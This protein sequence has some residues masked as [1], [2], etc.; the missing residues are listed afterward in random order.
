[1]KENGRESIDRPGLF[2]RYLVVF[3]E[4]FLVTMRALIVIPDRFPGRGMQWF[5]LAIKIFPIQIR[6]LLLGTV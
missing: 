6:G 1:L 5:L 3:F 4:L 2:L